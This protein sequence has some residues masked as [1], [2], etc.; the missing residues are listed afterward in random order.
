M[1]N[2]SKIKGVCNGLKDCCHNTKNRVIEKMC[3]CEKEKC[4][5]LADYLK[6]LMVI[7]QL[8]NYICLC[9]CEHENISSSI[10]SELKTKC[11]Q[12]LK[13]TKLV[14]K[15]LTKEQCDYIRCSEIKKYCSECK[16]FKNTKTKKK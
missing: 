3:D 9:C 8:C 5:Y 12:L 10:L 2:I 1:V 16:N 6:S 11:N 13:E 4:K 14:E 15:Y 7:E